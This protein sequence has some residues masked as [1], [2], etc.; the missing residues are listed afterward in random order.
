MTT[1]CKRLNFREDLIFLNHRSHEQF[2]QYVNTM[3]ATFDSRKLEGPRIISNF[4]LWPDS[5]K[6]E[7]MKIKSFTVYSLPKL[8]RSQICRNCT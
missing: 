8:S 1:Y 5:R 7:L 3:E 4:Q 6:F 2:G